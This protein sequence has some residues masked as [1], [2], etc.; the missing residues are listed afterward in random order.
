MYP[1]EQTTR[2]NDL[3]TYEE[4]TDQVH[5]THQNFC[6]QAISEWA[7]NDMGHARNRAP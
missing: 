3:I 6:P 5:Y 4:V 7:G 2:N 1:M